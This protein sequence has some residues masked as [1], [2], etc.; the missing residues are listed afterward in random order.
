MISLYGGN[1]FIGSNFFKMYSDSV[2]KIDRNEN[3]P[4]SNDILYFIST[5]DNYNIYTDPYIDIE[6][7]LIKL[8]DVL[9]ACNKSNFKN[10]T[11]NFVSS[12]FV[13]GKT[14]DLPAN[15]NSICNPTGFYSITKRA[16]EQMLI[17]Y[18]QT[19]NINYRIFRLTNI[20]GP[21]DKK[22]SKKK[23]A[24]QYMINCLKTNESI[25][26]YDGG[27]HIRDYM[28]VSDACR[29]M[30]IILDNSKINEIYNISNSNPCKIGDI[31]NYS[32]NKLNSNSKIL[33]IEPSEFHNIVQIKDMWLDNKKLLSYGYK[34][35]YG[36][37]EAIDKILEIS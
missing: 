10:I 5:V 35:E 7:N 19:F 23:N 1:G 36:I 37:Y 26:L 11:F 17:S 16:A 21:D 33:S 18:C 20:I 14:N 3:T 27:S 28:Y 9:D 4:K 22:I 8:I 25:S 29:A 32:R 31:I 13:Y 34:P 12:W 30:K 15:E 2:Y 6:T 24:L